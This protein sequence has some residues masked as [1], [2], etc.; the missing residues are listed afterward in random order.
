VNTVQQN[1]QISSERDIASAQRGKV[2][3]VTLFITF[4]FKNADP[5]RLKSSSITLRETLKEAISSR[6]S[7]METLLQV[8]Q[9]Q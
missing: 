4:I 6:V 7:T 5:S 3:A 1:Q 8:K 2:E 9:M